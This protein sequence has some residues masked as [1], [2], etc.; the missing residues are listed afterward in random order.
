MNSSREDRKN[1]AKLV[2][3]LNVQSGCLSLE[4]EMSI[5]Q[6]STACLPLKLGKDKELQLA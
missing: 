4:L 2:M 1:D 6:L 5:G 3:V